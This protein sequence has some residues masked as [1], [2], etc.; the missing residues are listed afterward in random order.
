MRNVLV[1]AMVGIGMTLVLG[2]TWPTFSQTR[3]PI[4]HNPR[5]AEGLITLTTQTGDKERIVV[6]DPARRTMAV[7][8]IDAETGVI[9]LKSVRNIQ[10]DLEMQMF[11][12]EEPHPDQIRS[13][14]HRR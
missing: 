9:A 5:T 10:W 6:V 3:N 4:P 14:L 7:Y 8:Q 1:A 11:N 12:S 2:A 13:M